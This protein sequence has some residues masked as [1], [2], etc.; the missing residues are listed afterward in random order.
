[1]FGTECELPEIYLQP[2]ESHFARRPSI[3]RTLLGS[4]VSVSF[5][6]AGAGAGA[7]CHALLPRCPKNVRADVSVAM[8][9]RYVDFAICDLAR[10]FDRLGVPRSEV[11]IKLF[12]G[13]DVLPINFSNPQRPTVGRQ[14]CE[15][16][17]EVLK[18]EGFL[19]SASSL[20]G[21]T[22]R[23]IQFFTGTGEVRLRWLAQVG[24][25]EGVDG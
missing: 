18:A 14:N 8:G 25:E 12:G 17:V 2:G 6:S 5:W 13:A 9:R 4:C 7:L 20:G 21:T 15:A 10:Q 3:I 16:A 24:F 11:Q 19:V 22:G 23:S 1:M